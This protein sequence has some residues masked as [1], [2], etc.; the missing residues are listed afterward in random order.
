[1]DVGY[2]ILPPRTDVLEPVVVTPNFT[3]PRMRGDTLEYN[4]T[5][6]KLRGNSTV[7]ELLR[8]L[9]GVQIDANGYIMVNGRRIER[10]L[11]DGADFFGQDPTFIT[12]NFNADMISKVQVL[13]TKSK[14]AE[15][16]GVDDEKKIRTLNLTLKEDSKKGY[17]LNEYLGMG[18]QRYYDINGAWGAFDRNRQMAIIAKTANEGNLDVIGG[19]VPISLTNSISDPLG[20]SA[21]V[22]IPRVA[23][24]GV[25][26]SNRSSGN[27]DRLSG[28][29]QSKW[30]WTKP[31]SHSIIRQNL[32]GTVYTQKLGANSTNQQDQHDLHAEYQFHVDSV[33][34]ISISLTG[35]HAEGNNACNA[36]DTSSFNDTLANYGIR[37]VQSDVRNNS[38]QGNILWVAHSRR[39]T[40][41]SFSITGDVTSKENVVEGFLH[42]FNYFYKWNGNSNDN[43]SADQKKTIDIHEVMANTQS[44]YVEPL[45]KGTRM[46]LSYGFSTTNNRTIQNTFAKQNDQYDVPI[47]SLSSFY[48]STLL[49]HSFSFNLN[50]ISK[51][52]NYNIG[53]N[54]SYSIQSQSE[55]LK[56]ISMR[57]KYA[58]VNPSV[59]IR[60]NVNAQTKFSLE[61]RARAQQPYF[62]Q[63]QPVINNNDPLHIKLG[64]PDLHPFM[65][66]Y[67]ET[68]FIKVKPI[69]VVDLGARME[70]TSN[71]FSVKSYTDSLGRQF[72]QT[73]NVDGCWNFGVFGYFSTRIKRVDLDI[74]FSPFC[75][76]YRNVNYVNN[77]LD[78][79]DYYKSGWDMGV[80]KYAPERYSVGV[81]FTTF[82]V[83]S[84]STLDRAQ[85]THY[86]S[87]ED[88]L[89]L[90][91]FF[92]RGFELNTSAS[93][94]WQ[95][96]VAGF[97]KIPPIFLWNAYVGWGFL[98]NQLSLRWQINDI[99]GENKGF[100]RTISSN[101]V[102]EST[103]NVIGRYWM[104][105]ASYRI[106]HHK[107]AE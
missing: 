52:M 56:K 65:S 10:L 25:H 68:H 78:R 13:D 103:S 29:Y 49:V 34:A 106:I 14:R 97:D 105:T 71:A 60:W 16:T 42:L 66:H 107:K 86:W 80:S 28:S 91:V 26:Y 90:S 17:L 104:L 18:A 69:I 74:R 61:Y 57:R 81:E 33:N 59:N 82:Y 39:K 87:G 35:S 9:P 75:Y 94:K 4:T 85:V 99:L 95:Q 15:F 98:K 3:G 47:D 20:A 55:G 2:I 5:G 6:V 73:V 50:G 84:T 45:W 100:T 23:V 51:N 96:D 93:F 77:N 54:I 36:S 64:N 32:P 22:G 43:D 44:S 88:K 67:I 24:A 38:L 41:R 101:L 27:D 63:L 46:E 31:A 40:G 83:S 19:L 8:R 76:Y 62:D 30:L 58:N 7:E 72:S 102:S 48:Q 21:G 37:N 89:Q 53:D 92:L 70:F 11:V 79:T 1:M 12:K